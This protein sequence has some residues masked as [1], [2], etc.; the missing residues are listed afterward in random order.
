[1]NETDTGWIGVEE[2]D[3]LR[4]K[5]R[6]R[7]AAAREITSLRDQLA[8]TRAELDEARKALD[9]AKRRRVLDAD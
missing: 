1:M 8:R 9:D 4:Q 3:L 6:Q 2:I 5:W 7:R